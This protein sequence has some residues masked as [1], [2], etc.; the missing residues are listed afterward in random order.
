MSD[1]HLS[2]D[3]SFVIRLLVSEPPELFRLAASYLLDRR[4]AGQAIHVSDLVLA[5][6]YFALQSYYQLSK[7]D[8]LAALANFTRH[9]GVTVTPVARAVLAL[10]NLG[11][12]KPGFVDRLI[13]G[14]SHASGHTLV[15]MEKAA[16]K[17]PA[18][19]VLATP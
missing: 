3:T 15:T 7:A 19:V 13:H 9:S 17:L 2:L 14:A 18:T 1:G 4:A 12:A 10:P 6:V 5:E 16:R 11:R 8:A